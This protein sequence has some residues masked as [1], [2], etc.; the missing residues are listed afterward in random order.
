VR[1]F[2]VRE[3]ITALACRGAAFLS[4]FSAE[5]LTGKWNSGNRPSSLHLPVGFLPAGCAPANGRALLVALLLP[6]ISV[7]LPALR[8]STVSLPVRPLM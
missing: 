3:F 1:K 7:P 8:L 4:R 6:T 5:S 2:G